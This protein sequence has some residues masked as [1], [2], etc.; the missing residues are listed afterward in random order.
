MSPRRL[1]AISR[2][3]ADGFRRD[4]PTL[5]LLFVVPIVITALLGWV[6]QEQKTS[7]TR[8]VVVNLDG[9]AAGA[10]FASAI[11]V[12]ANGVGQAGRITVTPSPSE[13]SARAALRDDAADVAI[14]IPAGFTDDLLGGTAPSLKVI[15]KGTNPAEDA[16]HIAALQAAISRAASSLAPPGAAFVLP[17]I[18][19]ET[20]YGSPD[21]DQLDVFGPVLIGFF[22][23]FLVYILTGISFLRERQGGTLE[24]LLATPVTRAEIVLGYGL[25][26]GFFATVQVAILTTWALMHV[27]L[28]AVDL[29]LIGHVSG[30]SLGLGIANAGNPLV[31]FLVAVVLALGA[32]N[33]G[34][35][36]STFARTELQIVQFI[37]IVIVPQGLLSGI[38]WPVERLPDL[39]QPIAR[40]LPLTYAVEGLRGVMIKGL[41]MDSPTI[42]L[43]LAVLLGIAA[44]F[45]LL[46]IGTIRR[47]IA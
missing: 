47:E 10:G 26:F 20:V 23:Y 9:G 18:A 22:A 45:V 29:P 27:D 34:I 43:D 39:L 32:V 36:L 44:F 41:G 37:P 25:G 17:T 15:T 6:L 42:Q 13:D 31:A 33:L 35:F 19:R 1:L 7:D 8:A 14:V 12:G 16:G 21:A 4:R 40:A 24:R 3:I 5:G 2:R 28:P 11:A 46:A 30:I 38:F